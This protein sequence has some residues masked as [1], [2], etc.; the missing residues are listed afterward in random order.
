MVVSPRLETLRVRAALPVPADEGRAAA[1]RPRLP[2]R[3]REGRPEVQSDG[4]PAGRVRL[5]V[6]DGLQDGCE[7]SLGTRLRAIGDVA[8]FRR[9]EINLFLLER[10]ER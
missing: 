9:H 6:R 8:S 5:S 10:L 4:G 1:V 7:V 3:C 2:R